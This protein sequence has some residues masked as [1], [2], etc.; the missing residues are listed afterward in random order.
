MAPTLFPTAAMAVSTVLF[1]WV[2]SKMQKPVSL[3]ISEG[4]KI[5]AGGFAGIPRSTAVGLS[6][7]HDGEA[8][9]R[10]NDAANANLGNLFIK[11]ST[12]KIRIGLYKHKG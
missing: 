7:L 6:L 5:I 9:V 3:S 12:N 11:N 4:L 2:G 1:G 10:K 8:G